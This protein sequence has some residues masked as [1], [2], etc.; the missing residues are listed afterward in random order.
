[1]TLWNL[2]TW[3]DTLFSVSY[4]KTEIKILMTSAN[5]LLKVFFQPNP[6]HFR[7]HIFINSVCATQNVVFNASSNPWKCIFLSSRN[8]ENPWILIVTHSLLSFSLFL[9]SLRIGIHPDVCVFGAVSIGYCRVEKILYVWVFLWV[10]S[11]IWAWSR[12]FFWLS[13]RSTC[14]ILLSMS[15]A[16]FSI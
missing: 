7:F 6:S 2:K 16:L 3:F 15:H 11:S 1:M 13:L 5:F 9:L 10:F 12:V 14:S 4:S 8:S